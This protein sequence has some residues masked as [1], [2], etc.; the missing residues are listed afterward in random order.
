MGQPAAVVVN[1]TVYLYYTLS[2]ANDPGPN[3]GRIFLATSKDGV[4]FDLVNP[5]SGGNFSYSQRDVSVTYDRSTK[6]FLLIQGDVGDKV[7][8]WSVSTNGVDFIPYNRSRNIVT[9]P[10][11]IPQGS[12]NNPGFATLP[13]GTI[14][15][16]TTSVMYGS[17][18]K[19]EWGYW[20]LYRSDVVLEPRISNCTACVLNSCD[21]GCSNIKQTTSVGTCAY[22]GS[23]DPAK[24]CS[25][26]VWNEGST[27]A[28]CA[29]NGCVSSCRM[30]QF[31]TGVCGVPGS[32]DPKYCCTCY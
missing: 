7:L 9:N 8:S 17:S 31:F 29:P 5:P 19:S 6:L 23:S 2:R 13:D 12:N 4:H 27:C 18:Y 30:A 20:H 10:E 32:T 1:E 26:Q 16:G 22:P 24:C 11:L 21:F 15:S 25:C 28:A 3:P 14:G